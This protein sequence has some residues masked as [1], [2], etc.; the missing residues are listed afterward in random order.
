MAG[1]VDAGDAGDAA[2]SDRTI[3]ID[4]DERAAL[5][6]RVNKKTAT[7]GASMPDTVT[8]GGTEVD[9]EA[10]VVETRKLERI[11]PDTA[12]RLEA[13]K[14]ALRD[15]RASRFDCLESDP[16]APDAA[17]GLAEEII[18]IDRALHS[19][20]NVR[21]PD[22]GDVARTASI[23]DHKRWVAFLDEIR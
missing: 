11:L 1:N 12:A 3:A 17:E 20:E 7:V 4:E 22:Y 8:V 9:L 18:G 14:R 21:Q 16:L 19:L 13:A 6:E 15:E 23:E 10:F 5:L 2:D